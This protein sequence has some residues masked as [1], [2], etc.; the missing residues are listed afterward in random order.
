MLSTRH[1]LIPAEVVIEMDLVPGFFELGEAVGDVLDPDGLWVLGQEDL[2]AARVVVEKQQRGALAAW[3]FSRSLATARRANQPVT[4]RIG[5]A[6]STVLAPEGEFMGSVAARGQLAAVCS[7]H[8]SCC[9]RPRPCRAAACAKG[10]S[11]IGSS[12]AATS[13]SLRKP[14]VTRASSLRT[15]SGSRPTF[16]NTPSTDHRLETNR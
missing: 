8:D 4:A 7:A 1:Q 10:Y 11:A 14:L 2:G 9:A 15:N 12:A 6:F 13:R 5:R 16:E 3:P